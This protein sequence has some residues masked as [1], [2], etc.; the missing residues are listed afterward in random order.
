MA[1]EDALGLVE[2]FVREASYEWLKM[3]RV[4]ARGAAC[5]QAM[6]VIGKKA[7]YSVSSPIMYPL[8]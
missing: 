3:R 7:S 8:F 5:S 6:E 2:G 1:F 4:R